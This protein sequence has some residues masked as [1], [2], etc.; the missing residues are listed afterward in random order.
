MLLL[1]ILF[2]TERASH[3]LS[4]MY[5]V[6]FTDFLQ[7]DQVVFDYLA[8]EPINLYPA[9]RQKAILLKRNICRAWLF[10][11]VSGGGIFCLP[12]WQV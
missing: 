9:R 2:M 5:T 12:E 8:V 3:W 1:T 7:T 6:L 4:G 10:S 11:P